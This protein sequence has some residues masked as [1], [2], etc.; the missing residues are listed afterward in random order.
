M[1]PFLMFEIFGTDTLSKSGNRN[2]CNRS[3]TATTTTTT[4]RHSKDAHIRVLNAHKSVR[5]VRGC[6]CT[7]LATHNNEGE[8][9]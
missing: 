2:G 6:A 3:E 1:F 7:Q 8:R 5:M 9:N 4:A